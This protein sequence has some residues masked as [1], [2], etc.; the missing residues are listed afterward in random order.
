MSAITHWIIRADEPFKTAQSF[1]L[2]D[3]TIAYTNGLTPD[4]YAADRG[5]PIRIV[6][7]AELMGMI[8]ARTLG[9]IT[10]PAEETC[11]Q[12]WDA[13]ECLPPSKY[14]TVDGVEMFHVCERIEADLVAWHAQVGGRFFT[15]NDLASADRT[16]L[17]A[18]FRA[19]AGE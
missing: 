17:A 14:G 10:A 18:K 1:L 6:T 5:F 19:A 7:D 9:L 4:T 8:E 11:E 13:L 3:G 16:Q 2:P 12:F 15:R